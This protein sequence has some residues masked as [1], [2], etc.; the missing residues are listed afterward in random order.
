[1]QSVS[2][3]VEVGIA[4]GTNIEVEASSA[5]GVLSSEVPLSGSPGK[6]GPGPTVVLRG[7]TVSGDVRLFRAA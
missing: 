1:M 2:G 7:Q 4:A 6:V 5:S 3:D